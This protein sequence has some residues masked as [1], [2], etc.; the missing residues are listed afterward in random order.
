[1]WIILSFVAV[2]LGLFKRQRTKQQIFKAILTILCINVPIG[3]CEAQKPEVIISGEIHT[4][5][6]NKGKIIV[7]LVDETTFKMPL[8]GIDTV[9]IKPTG[10][11]V[12]F[13]FKSCKR[14]TYGI[15]CFHDLNN[16]GTLDKGI[17][18]P[19]EPYGFS[20]KTG[21]KLPL[22]FNDISFSANSVKYIIIKM[23]E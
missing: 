19:T 9:I 16:N 22:K 2:Y 7:F 3:I 21:K 6:Q 15:R 11:I 20:W 23:E 8:T 17:F 1:M 5:I 12:H 13:T 14:G 18:G 4:T 10:S